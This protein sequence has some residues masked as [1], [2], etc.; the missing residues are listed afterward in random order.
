ME[1]C[2]A[3]DCKKK[4]AFKCDCVNNTYLCFDHSGLH[5]MDEGSH[6][7][8]R[9]TFFE[10]KLD[11]DAAVK[12]YKNIMKNYDFIL[13]NT[14]DFCNSIIEN[15]NRSAAKIVKQIKE[16]KIFVNSVIKSLICKTEIPYNDYIKYIS[17]STSAPQ[18]FEPIC[19]IIN[20]KLNKTFNSTL[21]FITRYNSMDENAFM[22][23][24]PE[25]NC[26]RLINLENSKKK[27]IFF[28]SKIFNKFCSCCRVGNSYFFYKANSQSST[29]FM[30]NLNENTVTRILPNVPLTCAGASCYNDKI[31]I[32]EEPQGTI[33][34]VVFPI[35]LL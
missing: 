25:T 6:F 28:D 10:T 18:D 32:L 31:Y 30:L 9:L 19:I 5:M 33:N 4:A 1:I 13:K 14:K 35:S 15:L 16:S 7:L 34:L 21:N 20:K 12:R 2:F 11:V 26:L 27:D 23:L 29:P 3:E 24:G 8:T 22:I 17:I